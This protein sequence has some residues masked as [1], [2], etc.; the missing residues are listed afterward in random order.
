MNF[1]SSTI[2][3]AIGAALGVAFGSRI[4]NVIPA[5][6]RSSQYAIPALA[7]VYLA[8]TGRP[9]GTM[10]NII[11]GAVIGIAAPPIAALARLG[12]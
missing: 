3:M 8:W 11:D 9:R 5:Q 2:Q 10:G 12:S 1:G 6:F 7:L 4:I